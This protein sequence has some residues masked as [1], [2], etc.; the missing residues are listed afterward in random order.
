MPRIV[1]SQSQILSPSS[2]TRWSSARRPEPCLLVCPA[3]ALNSY[4]LLS[5]WNRRWDLKEFSKCFQ[6]WKKETE[7][8]DFSKWL[9]IQDTV[10]LSVVS[11]TSQVPGSRD[12]IPGLLWS[13][14]D[15]VGDGRE[16]LLPC[17]T[18]TGLTKSL[19][20]KYQLDPWW[21]K[22]LGLESHWWEMGTRKADW[23]P[24]WSYP[25]NYMPTS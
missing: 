13:Q 9:W 18:W 6:H 1:S 21:E 15:V 7:K 19:H 8:M 2:L 3:H 23:F 4:S 24:T 17:R 25:E 10:V 5:K 11:S 22:S 20:L 16:H 14:R 12:E